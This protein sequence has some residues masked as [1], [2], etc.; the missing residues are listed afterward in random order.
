MVRRNPRILIVS[1]LMTSLCW[2]LF[3]GL[4]IK[5]EYPR[6]IFFI[7]RNTILNSQVIFIWIIRN[8]S[9][10]RSFWEHSFIDAHHLSI[11]NLIG[12]IITFL[13]RSRNNR[14]YGASKMS[15][16][17]PMNMLLLMLTISTRNLIM[18]IRTLSSW[19]KLR[20]TRSALT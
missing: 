15:T 2:I 6:I 10:G 5:L 3:I 17:K 1:V 18:S 7:I 8:F 19:D 13:C 20:R 16:S 9:N 4:D 12:S 11:H 14:A